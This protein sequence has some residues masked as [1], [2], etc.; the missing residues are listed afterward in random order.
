MEQP[1]SDSSLSLAFCLCRSLPSRDTGWIK[2]F[3]CRLGGHRG[4]HANLCA[5]TAWELGGIL[6]GYWWDGAVSTSPVFTALTLDCSRFSLS[7][8]VG[9]PHSRAVCLALPWQRYASCIMNSSRPWHIESFCFLRLRNGSGPYA[10][11]CFGHELQMNGDVSSSGCVLF[12]S[13]CAKCGTQSNFW[14]ALFNLLEAKSA[15][16]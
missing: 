7:F 1:V 4:S 15:L 12:Q 11:V 3:L 2:A 9:L 16:K 8:R 10:F 14:G 5:A 6:V 13:W